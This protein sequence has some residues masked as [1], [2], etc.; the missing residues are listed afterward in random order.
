MAEDI[1]KALELSGQEVPEELRILVRNYKM[2]VKNG[3]AERF[4]V[5]GYL[6]RGKRNFKV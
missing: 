4:K 3:E 2:K 6:G 1:L 5:S